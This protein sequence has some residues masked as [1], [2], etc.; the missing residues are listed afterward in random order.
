MKDLEK[1]RLHVWDSFFG[2]AGVNNDL[3]VLDTSPIFF[4]CM[5][6]KSCK[7]Q[8]RAGYVVISTRCAHDL[9]TTY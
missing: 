3:T 4:A 9:F 5:K 1:N 6:Y 2:V 7:V 8:F